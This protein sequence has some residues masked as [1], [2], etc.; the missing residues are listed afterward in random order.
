MSNNVENLMN[1]LIEIVHFH[2]QFV[3][4]EDDDDFVE[5]SLID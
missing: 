1:N 4:V 2:R 5:D 3:I